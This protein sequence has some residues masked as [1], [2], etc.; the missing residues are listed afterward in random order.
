MVIPTLTSVHIGIP[1]PA[2]A[3]FE[4]VEIVAMEHVAKLLPLPAPAATV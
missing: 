2:K 4:R 3:Y 1:A